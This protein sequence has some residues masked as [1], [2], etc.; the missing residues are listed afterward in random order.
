[1]GLSD[2]FAGELTKSIYPDQMAANGK[3]VCDPAVSPTNIHPVITSNFIGGPHKSP[4][5]SADVLGCFMFE[6]EPDGL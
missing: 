4:Y 3:S 6:T 5:K 1:M 2:F